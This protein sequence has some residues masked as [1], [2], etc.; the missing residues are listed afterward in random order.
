[1]AFYANRPFAIGP[2]MGENA[3]I[4]FTVVRVLGYTWQSALGA[5]FVAGV[6]FTLMTVFRLRQWMVD[7]IPP[8][9]RYSYAVGIGLFL[10]FIGL[11]QTGIVTHRISWC[12][13]AA[14]P[15]HFASDPACDLR[16]SADHRADHSARSGRDSHRA[17]WSLLF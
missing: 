4:A 13:S 7:A 14:W 3:F 16:I 6:L 17:Y 10:T 15:S 2:Y 11:N 12:A 1:M 8:T 5:V 9:L